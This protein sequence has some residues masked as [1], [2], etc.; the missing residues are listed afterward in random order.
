MNEQAII[1]SFELFQKEGYNGTLDDF[2]TL[3]STNDEALNDMF[4]LFVNEGYADTKEDYTTLIGVKKKDEFIVPSEEVDTELPTT[5]EVEV[6]TESDASF[7]EPQKIFNEYVDEIDADFTGQEEEFAVPEMRYKLRDYGFKFEET[8]M[9]GDK[10]KVTAPN[11]KTIVI[12]LDETVEGGFFTKSDKETAETLKDFLKKNQDVEQQFSREEEEYIK[13]KARIKDEKDVE[14]GVAELNLRAEEYNDDVKTYVAKSAELKEMEEV[15]GN[16]TSEQMLGEYNEGYKKYLDLKENLEGEAKRL[17]RENDGLELQGMRLDRNVGKWSEMKREQG[18][19]YGTLGKSFYEGVGRV[20]AGQRNLATDIKSWFI[21][22]GKERGMEGAYSNVFVNEAKKRGVEIPEGLDINN[23]K[24]FDSFLETVDEDIVSSIDRKILDA[25]RKKEKYGTVDFVATP[26]ENEIEIVYKGLPEGAKF[27]GQV[28]RLPLESGTLKATREGLSKM[29]GGELSSHQYDE[30][31]QSQFWMGSL[32]GVT[33]SLPALVGGKVNRV[34]NLMAQ[35]TD[36]LY[37][38]MANDPDFVDVPEWEKATVA[39]PIGIAVAALEDFGF[40]NVMKQKGVVSGI[41]MKAMGKVPK[42]ASVK[43]LTK[44]IREEIKSSGGRFALSAGI[45]ASA[46]AE[47]GLLQE[48][49]DIGG[50]ALYNLAKEKDMFRTPDSVGEYVAQVLKAAAQEA[51]GGF[52]LGV[53]NSIK[54]AYSKADFTQVSDLEFETFTQLTSDNK[55]Y[56][57]YK[58]ALATKLKQQLNGKEITQQEADDTMDAFER[59]VGVQQGIPTDMSVENQ[60]K[61][62]GLSLRLQELKSRAE[63]TNDAFNKNTKKEIA[64]VQEQIDNLVG[65]EVATQ[66]ELGI[67]EMVAP[68][69][70]GTNP[71]SS[72]E[73]SEDYNDIGKQRRDKT[74]A[75]TKAQQNGD[76]TQEEAIELRK[77]SF[78]NMKKAQKLFRA[79]LATQYEYGIQTFEGAYLSENDVIRVETDDE[80][81]AGNYRV[82]GKKI[83]FSPS[84]FSVGLNVNRKPPTL[85]EYISQQDN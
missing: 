59:V 7:T 29:I 85:A 10:M 72:I 62:L 39:I 36:H 44:V 83:N 18:T 76:I 2:K 33:E 34:A 41:I 47:T 21:S 58:T 9:F 22:F 15:Y 45:A 23:E 5:Q 84:S 64:K 53:P 37:E 67:E 19:W 32:K 8:G 46:E 71:L 80:K 49:T 20:L 1:D 68:E 66:E 17:S 16:L 55:S 13:E 61:A 12:D 40:R 42:G 77:E 52:V 31:A 25:I 56:Q 4:G 24:Q 70:V 78:E 26:E 48:I 79:N 74:K 11:K 35:V 81:F 27:S 69:V 50:K 63:G 38:E 28:A 57:E 65:A 54:A 30:L 82:R 3:M 60:K 75:I 43:T 6:S 73:V 51:V 14:K